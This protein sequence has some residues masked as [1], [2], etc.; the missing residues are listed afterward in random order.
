MVENPHQETKVRESLQLKGSSFRFLTLGVMSSLLHARYAFNF[1]HTVMVVQEL[2]AF[3]THLT[4]PT[5]CWHRALSMG[6]M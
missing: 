3:E 6:V 2:G 5:S 1:F 4:Q